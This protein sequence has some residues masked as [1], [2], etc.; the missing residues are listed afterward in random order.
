MGRPIR[1]VYMRRAVTRP[2]LKS[3]AFSMMARW[4]A[5]TLTL[6]CSMFC[7]SRGL[8][9][10]YKRQPVPRVFVH[11]RTEL[12]EVPGTGMNVVQNLQ[13]FRVQA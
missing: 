9:D 11:G 12:T 10:V 13:K 7:L 1:V 6:S 2:T 8:G 3:A 4:Y 5:D